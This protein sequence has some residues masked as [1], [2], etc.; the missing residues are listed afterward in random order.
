MPSLTSEPLQFIVSNPANPERLDAFLVQMFPEVS[1]SYL[2]KLISGGCVQVN[3]TVV[4]R[5]HWRV[6]VDDRVD[7]DFAPPPRADLTPNASIPLDVLYEDEQVIVL[8]KPAGMMVHPDDR[9]PS[10]T[11]VNALLAYD[12]AIASVGTSRLRPGIVHRLDKDVSGVMVVV[13]TNEMFL[14]LKRQFVQQEVEK[15]YHALVHGTFTQP[16]GEITLSIARSVTGHKMAARPDGSGK[17]ARTTY[18]VLEA[19]PHATYLRL[20][21][22]TGRTNQIRVHLNAIGHPVVGE[23]LYIPQGFRTRLTLDRLFLH[24]IHLSFLDLDGDRHGYT[25]PLPAE[26]IAMLENLRR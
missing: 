3:A 24:S 21:I 13:R 2:Q 22:A 12:P 5:P 20:R 25:A 15:E 7:V 11:L 8:N 16:T 17:S 6:A 14:W 26:L 10:G 19:F 18:E 1:R 4:L 9:H 23:T